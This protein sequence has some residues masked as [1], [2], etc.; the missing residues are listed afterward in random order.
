MKA[1]VY[2][3]YGEPEVLQLKEVDKPVPEEDEVLVEVHA[4]A[5]N[6]L[7]WHYMRGSPFPVR[8]MAGLLKPKQNILGADI[9]GRVE[10][11]GR[12]VEGFEVGDDVFG[13]IGVGGFAEYAAVRDELLVQKPENVTFEEAAAV[14]VA[15]LTKYSQSDLG[16][17]KEHLENGKI[18][19]VIDRGYT[20]SQTPEA[21]GYVEEGHARGKVIIEIRADSQ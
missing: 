2:A 6:P 3:R 18:D 15:D 13:G 21:V 17:L 5:V 16:I 1:I 19:P 8:F 14:P 12:E 7:D 11:T 4:A 10:G 9:A 20:L